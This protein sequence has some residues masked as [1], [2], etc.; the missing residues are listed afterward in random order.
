MI[1]YKSDWTVFF[2]TPRPHYFAVTYL[3][4]WLQNDKSFQQNRQVP[5][6]IGGVY[7]YVYI[8]F[9]FVYKHIYVQTY[10]HIR[11]YPECTG[12][13]SWSENWKWYISLPLVQLYRY[14]VSQS[15]EFCC[16][17]PLCCFSVSVLLLFIS[18]WLSPETFGFTLVHSYVHIYIYIHTYT[19]THTHTSFCRDT[20]KGVNIFIKMNTFCL[21]ITYASPNFTS[22]WRWRQHGSLKRWYATS[23]L[24]GVTEH[25]DFYKLCCIE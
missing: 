25:L 24:H 7:V 12:L 10:I 21:I 4:L 18:L 9:V 5:N 1:Q 13:V 15:S 11:V 20:Q 22:P 23:S 2:L 6:V 16:H 3:T 8:Y 14:I 19:H 17:D